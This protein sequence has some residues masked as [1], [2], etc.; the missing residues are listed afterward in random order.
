[1]NST[2]ILMGKTSILIT[3]SSGFIGSNIIK[4]LKSEDVFFTYRSTDGSFKIKCNN[5][6]KI[7]DFDD[8]VVLHLATYFSK[9]ND[10]EKLIYEGNIAFG[11]KLLEKIEGFKIKK[12]I[13]TNTMFNF[14]KDDQIRDLFYTKTKNEFSKLLLDFSD[15]KKIK[16]EE[17]FLDN[18]FGM[19]DKRKKIIPLIIESIYKNNENPIQNPNSFINTI[20]VEDV[21]QRLKISLFSEDVGKSC[22]IENK[23]VNILS[24]YEFL[25]EYYKSKVINS[26][27]LIYQ[28]NDYINPY[29]PIDYKNITRSNFGQALIGCFDE[30]Y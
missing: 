2:I 27:K 11:Q 22:F 8:I 5:N 18:T 10:D 16:Y 23:Q 6:K 30:S 20:Y 21:A 15:S 28:S 1:M 14:Y 9:K 19:F 29:P 4:S 24:I 25:N 12:I 13:Y 17:I 26:E 3:G 7:E